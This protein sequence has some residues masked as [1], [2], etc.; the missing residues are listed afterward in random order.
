MKDS[1][2][3]SSLFFFCSLLWFRCNFAELYSQHLKVVKLTYSS[4][5]S[6]QLSGDRCLNALVHLLLGHLMPPPQQD[7]RG[8]QGTGTG[9]LLALKA[10][11]ASS[12]ALASKSKAK[13]SVYGASRRKGEAKTTLYLEEKK[14]PKSVLA[15]LT[16]PCLS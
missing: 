15:G 10:G 2:R 4:S 14:S 11:P 16:R 5:R 12:T 3:G 8:H 9:E 1:R 13:H 6:R 7:T